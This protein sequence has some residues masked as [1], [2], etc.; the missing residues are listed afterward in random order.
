[1]PVSPNKTTGTSELAA[2]G[3]RRRQRAIAAFVVVMS[4]TLSLERGAACQS[5][6]RMFSRSWRIGSKAYSMMRALADNNARFAASSRLEPRADGAAVQEFSSG[7]PARRNA[8]HP[9]IR[10]R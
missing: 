5:Q 1:M 4:S 10:N 2:S 6:S 7:R 9:S 8:G 3:A